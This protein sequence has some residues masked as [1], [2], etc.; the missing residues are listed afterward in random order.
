MKQMI[1]I[2]VPFCRHKCAYCDFI[3]GTNFGLKDRYISAIERELSIRGC[4]GEAETLYFGGGTPS[5]LSVQD[6]AR[7]KNIV[8][9]SFNFSELKEWTVECNPEDMTEEWLS[10]LYDIGVNRLSVGIQSL[11]DEQLI[12]MERR[13]SADDAINSVKS[14]WKVGFSNISCDII[15]GVPGNGLNKTLDEVLK[16]GV[17]H[18]SAYSLMMEEGSKITR[19]GI[20]GVD[21]EKSAQMYKVI[22]SRLKEAGYIHYEISNWA[23]PGFES[24]HNSGYW[25]GI[26]Y[27]GLG[28]AAH[29]FDGVS[30]RRW[31]IGNTLKYCRTIEANEKFWDSETLTVDDCFNEMVMLGLRKRDGIDLLSVETRFGLDRRKH[32]EHIMQRFPGLVDISNDK[33]CLTEEG[34]Y[35]SDMIISEAFIS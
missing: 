13:H 18:I 20:N 15:F 19:K 24:I 9:S 31:N 33:C 7:L 29:S 27:V 22:A 3:S 1:Y 32:L 4:N 23:L 5:M 34:F 6:I 30:L 35:V 28:P 10:G 11:D 26:P 21:E 8:G 14:A 25:K 17:Q 16:L 2:H 12:W